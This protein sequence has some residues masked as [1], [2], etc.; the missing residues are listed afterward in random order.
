MTLE[1]R[2]PSSPTE[3][4]RRSN[5]REA[6]SRGGGVMKVSYGNNSEGDITKNEEAGRLEIIDLSGMSLDCLH[7]PS[8]VNV[9][10]I[11][12]LDLS[13][14]NLQ[15]YDI[16]F[17][18]TNHHCEEMQKHKLIDFIVQFMERFQLDG[19]GSSG[20]CSERPGEKG[21]D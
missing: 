5:G 9:A 6:R 15:G 11:C 8:M 21:S 2:Q 3:A 17:L 20:A 1:R 18:V 10:A 4:A 16:S 13:N 14:N 19:K 7:N 12:K